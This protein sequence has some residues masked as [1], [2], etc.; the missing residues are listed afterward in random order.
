MR[1]PKTNNFTKLRSA[2][3]HYL[4]DIHKRRWQW[5][6]RGVGGQKLGEIY[7]RIDSRVVDIRE[8]GDVC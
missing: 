6:N 1:H 8:T 4:R 2:V 7:G 5:I 3:E